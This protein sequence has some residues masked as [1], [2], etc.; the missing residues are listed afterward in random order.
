MKYIINNVS[1]SERI[2]SIKICTK[3]YN[4]YNT[5][6]Q[7]LYYILFESKI[8]KYKLPREPIGIYPT[9]RNKS[10]KYSCI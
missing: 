6:N 2:E 7:L 4:S 1:R 3:S 8:M 10:L 9:I 5:C